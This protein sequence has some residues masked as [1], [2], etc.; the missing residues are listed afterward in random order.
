MEAREEV[1]MATVVRA[2]A[3]AVAVA[4]E[5]NARVALEAASQAAPS[6]HWATRTDLKP[7]RAASAKGPLGPFGLWPEAG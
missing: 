2:L 7:G 3:M 4:P 6:E 5:G 1:G